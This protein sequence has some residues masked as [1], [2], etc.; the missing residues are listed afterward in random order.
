MS[1]DIVIAVWNLKKYTMNCI[2]S[3]INNTD[4]PYRLI[5]T[6]N[7][8]LPETKEYLESLK[9]DPRLEDHDYTLIRNEENLGATKALNQGLQISKGDYAMILNNDTICCKGWLTEMVNIAERSKDI[10][11]INPNSNNLG[12][13]KPKRMSLEEFS[14]GLMKKNKGKFKEMATAVGFCY[15]VKREVIN[16]IGILSE[17]YGL[18]NFEETEYCIRAS[19]IG[20]RSVYSKASYVW[21][22][23]H[24][25]FDLV[26][27]FEE[28]FEKNQK[29]FNEMFG[30]AERVL[31]LL[32]KKDLRYFKRLKYRTYRLA[33][34]RSWVWVISKLN[35]GEIPLSDHTNIITFRYRDFF[36][37]MRCIFRILVKKK[38]FDRILTDDDRL[39]SI[40]EGLKRFH[41]AKL[42]H[43]GKCTYFDDSEYLRLNIGCFGRAYHGYV[44]ID[45][46]K[47]NR[48]VLGSSFSDLPFEDRTVKNILLDYSSVS[49]KAHGEISNIL[50]EFERISVPGCVVTIDNFDNGFTDTLAKHN[51]VPLSTDYNRLFSTK[52]FIYEAP[53]VKDDI[54][55][56]VEGLKRDLDQKGSLKLEIPNES[57]VSEK[58]EPSNFFDK[59]S[60]AQLFNENGL[61]IDSLETRGDFIKATLG[62]IHYPSV[63][64][65]ESRKRVCA[66][67]Q[68]MLWRYRNLG[69]DWDTLPRSFEK[70]GMECLLL[71][72]MRNT[73]I[74]KLQN[75][76]LSF[77]PHYLFI[78]LKDTLPVIQGIEKELRSIGTKVIYW[79][80]DPEHPKKQDL[81]G[82]ID[83]MFLTNRGQIDEYKEAYNLKRVY[84]MPQGYGPYAQHRLNMREAWDVGFAGAVSD[85]PLHKTRRELIALMR[86]KY[87]LRA[88]HAVR[89]NIAEFYSQSKTVF[90]ASDFDYELYT[91]NR[92][93]VAL[94]C[95]TCYIAKKFKGIELLAENKKHLLWFEDKRELFDILDYYLSRDRER[96]KIRQNA[97][98]LALEKHTYDH[99]MKNILDVMDG[100]TESFYGFL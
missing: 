18:G 55:K 19:R 54:Q 93:F 15:M 97:A 89:N 43:V 21:H 39:F 4:Y 49:E 57:I 46:T 8:S 80:C 95:G 81:S 84:Y 44:N 96:E 10:G 5:I 2:E 68:Y 100:K 67:G 32:T 7:G 34:K 82:V 6:D 14:Q 83:T 74:K 61:Y 62:K 41:K 79:F 50:K 20:Y 22:K 56:F 63:H 29:M 13:R 35:L 36:F 42:I 47:T 99:R 31:Y 66:I 23:E 76:I 53:Y 77:K 12:I 94:G 52:S 17:E 30:R 65:P 27:D 26:K 73:E 85:A 40:L 92:F 25:S 33:Q 45:E 24:A 9:K 86:K 28:M 59:G 48:R 72:G 78:I 3:I 1:C 16:K 87:S 11:I 37:R 69:F 91:S 98:Q 70:L 38:K 88:S 60:A 51:F 71:E 58:G 75:A 64:I 90:G